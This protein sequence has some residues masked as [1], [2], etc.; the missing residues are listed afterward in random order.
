MTECSIVGRIED[1]PEAFSLV[2]KKNDILVTLGAGS[3][4]EAAPKILRV[5]KEH[6]SASDEKRINSRLKYSEKIA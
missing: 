2:A 5:I 1:L 3:I 6:S 4:T